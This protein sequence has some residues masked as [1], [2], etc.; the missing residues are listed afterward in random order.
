M[1]AI[2]REGTVKL[3]KT[4]RQEVSR[5]LRGKQ[6][7]W[8]TTRQKPVPADTEHFNALFQKRPTTQQ[9]YLLTVQ[10]EMN[11]I[12]GIQ[13]TCTHLQGAFTAMGTT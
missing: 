3:L 5:T 12:S 2:P 13:Q 4:E 11:T 8:L 9:K 1:K 6:G 7:R 10:D